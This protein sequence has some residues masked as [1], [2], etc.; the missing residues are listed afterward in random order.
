[1]FVCV[2]MYARMYVHMHTRIQYVLHV[3]MYVWIKMFS[4]YACI[5]VYVFIYLCVY[6]GRL[7]QVCWMCG[8][9]STQIHPPYM[10]INT[11][12]ICSGQLLSAC[13]YEMSALNFDAPA[14]CSYLCCISSARLLREH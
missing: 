1:M 8:P 13:R 11:R 2:C 9:H 7:L 4:Q 14:L 6:Q 10:C 12:F 5:Y 3:G